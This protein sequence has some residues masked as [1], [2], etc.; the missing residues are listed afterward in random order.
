MREWLRATAGGMPRRFWLLWTANLIN[1]CGNVVFIVL[2][3]FLSAERHLSAHEVGLVVGLM[4]AGGALGVLLGGTLADRWGRRRTL[5]LAQC[6]SAA[7]LLVLGVVSTVPMIAAVGLVVGT[8]QSL[9]RPAFAATTVDLVAPHDRTRAFSLTVW[10]NNLAFVVAAVLAGWLA[11]VDY[12][13]VF[14]GDAATALVS[15]LIVFRRVGETRPEPVDDPP[16]SAGSPW[17]DGL[18]L[19]LC[20]LISLTFLVIMQFAS[21]LPLSMAR[22]G[23]GAAGYGAIMSVNAVV[24]IVAQP[25]VPRLLRGRDLTHLLAAATVVLGIGFGLTAVTHTALGYAVTVLV[26]AI[27]E[28]LLAPGYSTL[29][30]D[31]SPDGAR[32]RYQGAFSL[33]IAG[34]TIAAPIAGTA[35]LDAFGGPALWLGCLALAFVI[36][37]GYFVARP[38][39]ARRLTQTEREDTSAAY[40]GS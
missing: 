22:D 39:W 21:T 5:L 1:R 26:W 29:V 10:S 35:V 12:R 4:G 13:L 11:S 19:V 27:G 36:A 8:A 23:L 28:T 37:A 30:A 32:G 38:A 34:S 20:A 14:L 7:A 9:A 2:T 3:F 6:A 25:F 31:M 15:G 33:G 18:F 17:R 40:K 24:I 16:A